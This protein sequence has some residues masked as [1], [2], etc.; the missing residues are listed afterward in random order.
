MQDASHLLGL[1]VAHDD[2]IITLGAAL[3]VMR[4]ELCEKILAVGEDVRRAAI[5]EAVKAHGRALSR[6]QSESQTSLRRIQEAMAEGFAILRAERAAAAEK[7]SLKWSE[8][9]AAATSASATPANVASSI[10]EPVRVAAPVVRDVVAPSFIDSWRGNWSADT[11]YRRGDLLCFR[12]ACYL[13]LRDTLGQKPTRENQK[14]ANAIFALVVAAGAPG[15]IAP[16]PMPVASQIVAGGDYTILPT[17]EFLVATNSVA[18]TWTLYAPTSRTD[19]KRFKNRGAGELTISGTIFAAEAVS[20]L[21]LTTGDMATL[22][23][24]GEYWNVGD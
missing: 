18:A 16:I 2:Q 20:S 14:G 5:A 19:F 10:P 21:V 1:V 3:P 6:V 11:L 23:A 13:A 12:G 22:R 15:P 24:D 17:D 8:L 9:A 7:A 4:A